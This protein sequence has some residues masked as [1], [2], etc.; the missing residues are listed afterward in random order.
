MAKLIIAKDGGSVSDAEKDLA[1]TSDR[2]CMIELLSGTQTVETTEYYQ[3]ALGYAPAYTVFMKVIDSGIVGIPA[4]SWSPCVGFIGNVL[5]GGI[6]TVDTDKLY[7]ET[8]QVYN[9]STEEYEYVT[10][11]FYYSIFANETDDAIGTGNDN[12]TGKMK[13]AKS[14]LS[15]PN[16]T[17]ARQYQFFVGNVFKK[18]TTLSG[19]V[20]ITT[21]DYDLAIVEVTH[22]LGYVPVVYCFDKDSGSRIP[23]ALPSGL[24]FSYYVTSTKLY[25]VAGDF[26]NPGGDTIS[27]A[28]T[29]LRDKIA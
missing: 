17:D 8:Y 27:V 16:I 2:N 26:F 19:S 12:V 18:D 13:V 14:G 9:E 25:I 23:Y 11:Q 29:I 10:T 1:F 7:F 4:N 20:D 24:M 3:H 5:N 28:Y 21:V 15:I 22:N 6:A